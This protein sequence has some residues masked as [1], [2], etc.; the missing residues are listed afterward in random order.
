MRFAIV[1]GIRQREPA[2]D[3]LPA[4][5]I[6]PDSM[7]D[8]DVLALAAS[9][10]RVLISHDRKTMPGYVY[11]FLEKSPSP[12]IVLSPQACPIREAIEDLL[13]LCL[14]QDAEDF[15]NQ[16]RYLPL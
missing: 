15:V 10:G 3:I 6:I 8:P 2:I 4:N 16:I 1:R 14:C 9:L 13:L 11:R 12:G 5:V 7:P